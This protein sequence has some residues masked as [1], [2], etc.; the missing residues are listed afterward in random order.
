MGGDI[1]S[2]WDG[3]HSVCSGLGL[4]VL[5]QE[6][7]ISKFSGFRSRSQTNALAGYLGIRP[8]TITYPLY[9]IFILIYIKLSTDC[10]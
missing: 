5:L 4:A 2:Y 6:N 9:I 8:S 3:G 1:D 7:Q 10:G